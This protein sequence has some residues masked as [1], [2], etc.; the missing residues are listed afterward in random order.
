MHKSIK[1]RNKSDFGAFFVSFYMK[2]GVIMKNKKKQKGYYIFRSSRRD[3][4]TGKI[5]YASS[6]GKKAFKIWINK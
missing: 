5:I 6:Y 3:P 1:I 2:G 4:K